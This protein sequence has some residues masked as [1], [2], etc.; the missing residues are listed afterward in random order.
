MPPVKVLEI[1]VLAVFNGQLQPLA[2]GV[3]HRRAHAVKAAGDLIPAAAELAAGVEDGVGHRCGG[4]SL[5]GMDA[6]GDAAA[7][8][9][10]PDDIPFQDI[11]Q[12]PV[13]VACQRLVNGVVHDFVDQVVQA[14]GAGGADIHAGAFPHGLQA[15]QHLDLVFVI[16]ISIHGLIAHCLLPPFSGWVWRFIRIPGFACKEWPGPAGRDRAYARR[17]APRR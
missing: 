5:L 12:N 4:D 14:G 11:H 13:A 6:H 10:D 7:V 3:D 9:H 16:L 15:L 1:D 8:V 2:Q 17:R